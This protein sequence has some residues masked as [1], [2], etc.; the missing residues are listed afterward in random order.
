MNQLAIVEEVLGQSA[1]RVATGGGAGVECCAYFHCPGAD[2]HSTPSKPTDCQVKIY[3]DGRMPSVSCLHASCETALRTAALAIIHRI[4]EAERAGGADGGAAS[5]NERRPRVPQIV[6]PAM[7]PAPELNPELAEQFAAACPRD[8]DRDFLR[9]IS[10]VTIPAEPHKWPELFLDCLYGHRDRILVFTKFASQGQFLRV[11]REKNYSLYPIPGRKAHPVPTL[12]DRAEDGVWFLASPVEGTWKENPAMTDPRT[13]APKI[14]RRHAACCT[15]FP[16]AV[17]ESDVLPEPTWLRILARIRDDIAAIYTSGG[18]SIHALIRLHPTPQSAEQFNAHRRA[19]IERLVPLGA[20]RAAITAV[21]LSR[22][23]GAVRL[24]KLSP[25]STV[26]NPG[27][28]LQ[29]LLYLNPH[30]APGVR[31][32]DMPLLRK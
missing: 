30:P 29:R 11:I 20:D 7:P 25:G 6:R 22:L 1:S 10:P 28:A 24:S 8:I 15:A 3:N 31:L 17:L 16:Y 21:R 5:A 27:D 26:A 4:R 9:R 2:S 13:G 23:P 18:K 19:L 14:G 32:C 12:P